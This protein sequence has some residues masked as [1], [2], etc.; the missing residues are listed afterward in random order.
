M[1]ALLDVRGR[2]L[3]SFRYQLILDLQENWA[4]FG[5]GLGLARTEAGTTVVVD[6]LGREY[7]W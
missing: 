4:P 5:G 3:T 2:P 7:A 1:Y 6:C